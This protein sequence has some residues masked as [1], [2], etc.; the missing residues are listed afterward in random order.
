VSPFTH[1]QKAHFHVHIVFGVPFLLIPSVST[2]S[3]Y[4]F[5]PV[6]FVLVLMYLVLTFTS[7]IYVAL[8]ISPFT[9][10]LIAFF[11]PNRFHGCPCFLHLGW[12]NQRSTSAYLTLYCVHRVHRV[13]FMHLLFIYPFGR[14]N[15]FIW[16]ILYILARLHCI[17]SQQMV[18]SIVP[19]MKTSSVMYM[20]HMSS[21]R[22]EHTPHYNLKPP[23]SLHFISV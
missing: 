18:I 9:L 12:F 11:I 3:I 10:P 19:T 5:I 15:R 2:S 13:C 23:T 8:N 17:T 14:C 1:P 20:L 21:F 22:N 7:V 6:Y 16:W 4:V